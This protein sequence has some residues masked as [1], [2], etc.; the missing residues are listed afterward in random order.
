MAAI[1]PGVTMPSY[2]DTYDDK[3]DDMGGSLVTIRYARGERDVRARRK[4]RAF[5]EQGRGEFE[6]RG[7]IDLREAPPGER[8]PPGCPPPREP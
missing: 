8:S 4:A 3:Y 7:G 5:P 2:D 6:P 1:P